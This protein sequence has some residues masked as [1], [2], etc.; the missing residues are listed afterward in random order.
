[1][2]KQS[3]LLDYWSIAESEGSD[4]DARSEIL[5]QPDDVIIADRVPAEV[6]FKHLYWSRVIALQDHLPGE[7][8]RWPLAT[9]ILE[10]SEALAALDLEEDP[11]W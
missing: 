10:S 8:Q 3:S 7:Q 5:S 11:D 6:K 2:R 1:M 9:D 4:A